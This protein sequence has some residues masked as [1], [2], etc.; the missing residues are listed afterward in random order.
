MTRLVD[1]ELFVSTAESGSLSSAARQLGLSPA[2]AS[3][4]LKRL[5]ETLGGRLFV[6]STRSQRLTVE[7]EV[8]L[9]H[10]QQALQALN[11]GRAAVSTGLAVIQ[12]ILQLSLP[13]DLGRN[14]VLPLIDDFQSRHPLLQI[15]V[16]CSDRVADV[17]RQPVDI[18]LRYGEQPDS[19]LIA[20]SIAPSNRRVLCAAPSYIERFGTPLQPSDLAEHN[21][22]IYQLSDQFHNRWTFS[23]DGTDMSV[24]VR[25][26]RTSDDGEI[27]RRWAV[28]GHGIAYKS[29][30]DVTTDLREGRLVELCCE[31]HTEVAP[32]NMICTDRRQLNPA[33][34]LLRAFLVEKLAVHAS[35]PQRQQS[36]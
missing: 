28:A 5:E 33:V 25:G 23:R 7:G 13:S 30:L 4:S 10:C 1:L 36:A 18:A 21:C 24:Q 2:T 17:Y 11:D 27:V 31:W 3:A 35:Q 34:Q 15:R 6:R 14:V 9:E 22:L 20:L 32:L 8:F 12:G 26:D 29:A 19:R 16:H